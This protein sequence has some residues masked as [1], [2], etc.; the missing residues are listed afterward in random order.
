MEN[1]LPNRKAGPLP[2]L[3]SC[4]IRN[5]CICEPDEQHNVRRQQII[6]IRTFAAELVHLQA[7]APSKLDCD[8]VPRDAR[9]VTPLVWEIFAA[10]DLAFFWHHA[11]AI[12]PAYS[13]KRPPIPYSRS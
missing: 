4:S 13:P 1:D 8:A 9:G 7:S 12:R 10:I 5:I 3:R 11:S 6:G 2:S